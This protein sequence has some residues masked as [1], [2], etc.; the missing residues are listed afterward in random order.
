MIV[1]KHEF[2]KYLLTSKHHSRDSKDKKSVLLVHKPDA[3]PDTSSVHKVRVYK[4]A[5]GNGERCV[6]RAMSEHTEIEEKDAWKSPRNSPSI[7]EGR[8]KV[9]LE[10]RLGGRWNTWQRRARIAE[11]GQPFRVLLLLA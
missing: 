11:K 5:V 9:H 7:L 4:S 2:N 10:Q 8:F 3:E 6:N 1:C